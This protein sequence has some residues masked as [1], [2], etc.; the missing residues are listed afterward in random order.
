M[1]EFGEKCKL[2]FRIN[3][4]TKLGEGIS[5]VGDIP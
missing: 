4:V 3:Y 2:R 5:M 1:A